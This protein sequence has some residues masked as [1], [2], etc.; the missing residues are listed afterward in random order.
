M[1]L[2]L[3]RE[4]LQGNNS[5]RKI[6][7][8]TILFDTETTGLCKAEGTRLDQQPYITELFMAKIDDDSLEIIGEYEQR[9]KVPVSLDAKVTEITGLKDED[10]ADKNPFAKHWRE[11]AEFVMGTKRLVAHNISFDKSLLRYELQ[12]LGKEL[13]F[14]WPPEQLCTIE[15]SMHF[16]NKRLN[17]S[18][19]HEHLFGVK[20]EGAHR[21]REDVMALLRCYKEMKRLSKE[22]A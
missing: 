7:M 11:I 12:R 4:L 9:F 10:L 14:P 2:T 5:N 16:K 1:I 22:A 8:A 13:N 6:N 21:A 18:A 20:F 17:L 19:L 15:R 3:Q